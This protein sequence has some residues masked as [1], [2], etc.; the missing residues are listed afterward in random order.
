MEELSYYRVRLFFFSFFEPATEDWLVHMIS[1]LQA[2]TLK[3]MIES[4][5][6]QMLSKEKRW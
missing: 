6:K 5:L 3:A 2:G 4:Y 1:L